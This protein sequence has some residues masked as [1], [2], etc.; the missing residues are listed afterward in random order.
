MMIDIIERER[1]VGSRLEGR[2]EITL[3]LILTL[4]LTLYPFFRSA[5]ER[6]RRP[7]ESCSFKACTNS[8]LIPD[9]GSDESQI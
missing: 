8:S 7:A 9:S 3:T 6:G 5:Q 1:A 2:G 4:T